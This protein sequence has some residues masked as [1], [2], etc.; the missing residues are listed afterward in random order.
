M[1][2]LHNASE[3]PGASRTLPRDDGPVACARGVLEAVLAVMVTVRE[4]SARRHRGE[5][6]PSLIH[7]RAM[8]VLSKRPG[9]TLSAL[10]DQ[11]GLTLSA[12]S[13]LVD[14]LVAKGAV[15]RTV[16]AG[17]RR[18]VSLAL[19]PAGARALE[20]C[21]EVTQRELADRLA[22]LTAAQRRG[23]AASTKLLRELFDG[24]WP[25]AGGGQGRGRPAAGGGGERPGGGKRRRQR[26]TR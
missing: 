3:T 24:G 19:T 17:N 6:G 21:M 13:R 25:A 2:Q 7:V 8:G 16:P 12:T 22:G 20:S 23:M 18:T 26:S 15:A 14:A 10:S 11:L 9:A 1:Q 4:M 5:T